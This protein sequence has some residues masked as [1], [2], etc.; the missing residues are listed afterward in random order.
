M[1]R[2]WWVTVRSRRW[3]LPASHHRAIS[4]EFAQVI[5]RDCCCASSDL[6]LRSGIHKYGRD[7]SELI[8]SAGSFDML[9][10]EQVIDS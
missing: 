2:G 5:Q 6:W 4:V 7:A 1:N 9:V 10:I 8:I 3:M